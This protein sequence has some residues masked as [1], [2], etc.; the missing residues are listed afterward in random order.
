[1]PSAAPLLILMGYGPTAAAL[2]VTG[3]LGGWVAGRALLKRLLI[4]RV[5]WPWYLV[6]VF[7]NAAVILAA[8]GLYTALG[9]PPQP[10]PALG[11]GL[12]LNVLL[13]LLV[14]SL[15]NGEEIGWRGFAWPRLQ[16]RWSM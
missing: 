6:A 5:G 3:V 9:G 16:A 4:W 7:L 11:P 2:L 1:F 14:V 8:L 15:V 10:W 13:T 12:L